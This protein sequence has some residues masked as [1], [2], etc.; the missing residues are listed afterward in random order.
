MK[1]KKP[2]QPLPL[3]VYNSTF[4]ATTMAGVV[5]TVYLAYSHYK[6]Y[7]DI[8]YKSFCAIS[9]SLN[10]DTVSQSVYA[11]LLGVP[12]AVWG[13]I[14]YLT[15][16]ALFILGS[17]AQNRPQRMWATIQ[18]LAFL[19]CLFDLFLAWISKYRI[20]SYC[21][22]CILTYG[23]N[24]AICYFAWL[25][26]RRFNKGSLIQCLQADLAS[27]RR[28]A[29]QTV[30]VGMFFITMVVSSVALY[31]S[32]WHYSLS[33]A[34]AS[35]DTGVNAEGRPWIGAQDPELV[36]EE[37]SD[38][39][40]F[41]CAKMHSYLRELVMRYPDK[42]RLVHYHFP[43]D[44]AYNPLVQDD[45]HGGSGRMAL[46]AIYAENHNKYWEMNDL[47]FT[48]ARSH[49]PVGLRMLSAALKLDFSDLARAHE[50]PE[51]LRRLWRDIR[52]GL[53][54]DITATPSFLINGVVYQGVIPTDVLQQI[55][56]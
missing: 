41:Q 24:F 17:Q 47:L 2:I 35:V 21:I 56:E 40:C 1:S 13:L 23:V 26:R 42:L 29:T 45:F 36:I 44:Q 53:K 37:Y 25:I 14:G 4:L 9:R 5:V 50:D 18:V 48:N 22:M 43:M 31:P 32:Y 46:L 30:L 6:V 55:I 33:S 3:W 28:Q 34:E 12:L 52:S 16:L 20:G 11:V 27:L 10:C 15:I 7:N 39:L 51:L 38:Y 19:F 8:A 54:H 49:A